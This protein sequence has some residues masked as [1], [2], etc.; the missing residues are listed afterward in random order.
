VSD[1]ELM[2]RLRFELRRC[3][4]GAGMSQAAV[5]RQLGITQKHMSALLTGRSEMSFPWARRIAEV[6]GYELSIA[7]SR[8][9]TAT[10]KED[11]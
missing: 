7:F 1:E 10:P 2:S 8:T 5:A 6:C 11:Q 4:L 9:I 3:I